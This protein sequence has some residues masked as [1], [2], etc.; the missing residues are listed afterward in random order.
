MVGEYRVESRLGEG[1]MGDVFQGLHPVIGKRVAI[2]VLKPVF[3]GSQE[4]VQRF[5]SEAASVNRICHPNIVDVFAFGQL[6]DGRH[7]FVMELLEGESFD[8]WLQRE[9]RIPLAELLPVL[10]QVADALD[11]AH[12]AGVIHRDLKPDNI[13][14]VTDHKG[15]RHA[16]V[17][18]FG[19]A[20]FAAGGSHRTQAGLVMGTPH[21]MSPEQCR[22]QAV[23][24]RA[25]VY[26]F[27]VLTYVALT[28][29]YPFEADSIDALLCQHLSAVPTMPSEQGAPVEL[30]PILAKALAKRP[31]D[32][33][34]TLGA[35]VADLAAVSGIELPLDDSQPSAPPPATGPLKMPASEVSAACTTLV[36][37]ATS[38]DE[39]VPT[40]AP[41]EPETDD[42]WLS[43]GGTRHLQGHRS[44]VHTVAFSPDSQLLASA[45]D[46]GSVR[47]WDRLGREV[48]LITGKVSVEHV[49]FSPD[50]GLLAA[51]CVDG[52]VKLW[53]SGEGSLREL[54]GHRKDVSGLAFTN[55]GRFVFSASRDGTLRMWDVETGDAQVLKGH[56]GVVRAVAHAPREACVASAGYDRTVRLWEDL[57]G[58]RTVLEGHTGAVHV[59]AFRPDGRQLASAGADATIH[60][61]PLPASPDR[62]VRPRVIHERKGLIRSIAYAPDGKVLASAGADG[63]VRLW[64]LRASLPAVLEGHEGPVYHVAFSPD[65]RFLASSSLDGT[66]R[67][68]DVSRR[69]SEMI[70]SHEKPATFASFSPD[71]SMLASCGGAPTVLLSAVPRTEEQPAPSPRA[72]GPSRPRRVRAKDQ[73]GRLALLAAL[74]ALLVLLVVAAVLGASF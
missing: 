58:R 59:L 17:V 35:V 42:E 5:I 30:D 9:R 10:R 74:A 6:D 61:W 8:A 22:G 47:I 66:V 49:V 68:W 29:G 2:K 48:N 56:I 19:I 71:G 64:R 72:E 39:P 57:S 60:V 38:A 27:G 55:D 15:R 33:Y 36:G 1:G 52:T 43:R 46:D 11:A 45:S 63:N 16:K 14:V 13:H 20:K 67:L 12:A 25:D 40:T 50:G 69:R 18:D 62:P 26:S 23:D 37:I 4:M 44:K 53:R 24:H 51:G 21:F 70:I 73:P 34:P 28:G 7:Y 31:E 65:G 32:R 3:G 41:G 54:R